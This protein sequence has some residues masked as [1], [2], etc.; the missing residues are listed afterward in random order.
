MSSQ[1]DA[2]FKIAFSIASDTNDAAS[3]DATIKKLEKIDELRQKMGSN[4]SSQNNEKSEASK[5]TDNETLN[6]DIFKNLQPEFISIQ[7]NF[8]EL[9]KRMDFI[10]NSLFNVATATPSQDKLKD[11]VMKFAINPELLADRIVSI[12]G[13][14]KGMSSTQDKD[15]LTEFIQH[16]ANNAAILQDYTEAGTLFMGA[17]ASDKKS[18]GRYRTRLRNAFYKTPVGQE[19]QESFPKTK[20]VDDPTNNISTQQLSDEVDDPT[21]NISTQQLSDELDELD[22]MIVPKNEIPIKQDLNSELKN[23]WKKVN[24][25]K[26]SRVKFLE[27]TK[28]KIKARNNTY[29]DALK[30]ENNTKLNKVSF[31]ENSKNKINLE[32][33]NEIKEDM[34]DN[35][36]M[37][38]LNA[39]AKENISANNAIKIQKREEEKSIRDELKLKKFEES[40]LKTDQASK[41]NQYRAQIRQKKT[42]D[43]YDANHA[44]DLKNYT[45]PSAGGW[46]DF[47]DPNNRFVDFQDPG[48]NYVDIKD[49]NNN[50]FI[51]TKDDKLDTI[52]GLNKEILK[53][54]EEKNNSN[55]SVK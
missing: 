20:Q 27:D 23:I 35:E 39:L 38:L 48:N 43:K 17:N 7:N 14:K 29:I 49:P 55:G 22:K 41:D 19:W 46:V 21:N 44:M 33:D 50:N 37:N 3:L 5:K 40:Q 15:I 45:G 47:Q 4:T 42:Q 11:T 1:D 26:F 16:I 28:N 13:T 31:L 51:N 2:V 24:D 53:N 10:I 32:E 18:M 52:I 54:V 8:E 36:K 25:I 9:T 34:D 6:K 30:K 12:S